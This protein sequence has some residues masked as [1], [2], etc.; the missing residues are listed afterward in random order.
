MLNKLYIYT[1]FVLT[2]FFKMW[3]A[4]LNGQEAGSNFDSCLPRKG[5]SEKTLAISGGK[6]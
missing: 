2:L 6:I 4:H 3:V 1:Y 5:K